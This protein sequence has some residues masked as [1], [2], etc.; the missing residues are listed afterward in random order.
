MKIGFLLFWLLSASSLAAAA[1]P[2]ST[3]DGPRATVPNLDGPPSCRNMELAFLLL[4]GGTGPFFFPRDGRRW[5]CA[6]SDTR[7]HLSRIEYRHGQFVARN[8]NSVILVSKERFASKSV[9]PL[10]RNHL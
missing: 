4:L 5:T 8:A 6:T 2:K 3:Q 10:K 1:P 7:L 9:K